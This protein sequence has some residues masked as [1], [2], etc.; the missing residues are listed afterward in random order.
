MPITID[1]TRFGSLEIPDEAVIEFPNGLIGL[2]G[3][4]YTL[5]TREESAPFLWLHSVD[6]GSLAIPMTSPPKAAAT[7]RRP[8]SLR[9][10]SRRRA[11][12]ATAS[13]APAKR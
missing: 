2:G 5:L 10:G 13:A 3:T 9:P 6:D 4:R 11:S 7:S 12:P 1:S 8:R